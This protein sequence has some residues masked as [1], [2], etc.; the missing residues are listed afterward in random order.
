MANIIDYVKGLLV[1]PPEKKEAPQVVLT[2]TANYHYRRD[3]YESYASEGY[4][5]NAIV[6][7]CVNEIAN[8]AASIKFKAFQGD[9]ELDEHPILSL[10]A[11]PNAQQAGV[12]YFQSL[13]SFL[14]LGG[15]SYAIRSDV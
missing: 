11:R 8:G 7:R 6:F 15:N 12:E 13:Y 2:S 14:L 9:I 10:L 3:N 5:Q 1:S 4:Q